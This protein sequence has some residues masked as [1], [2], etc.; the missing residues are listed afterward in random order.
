ML[1]IEKNYKEGSMKLIIQRQESYSR[2][3][4]LLRSFFGV[5]Y[6]VIPHMFLMTFVSIWSG[7]LS[8][9][10]F[11][12]VLFTGKYPKSWFEFQVKMFSWSLRL[13]ASLSN[14]IDGYP[15]NGVNGTSDKVILDVEYPETLSRGELLLRVFFGVIYIVIP[16]MFILSFRMI[17]HQFLSFLSWWAVLFTGKF[18]ESWHAFIVGTFRW[19]TR[20]SLYMNY[21]TD[22][23]PPFSGKE[24]A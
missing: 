6:I 17:A 16:H 12:V 18:P 20:L 3:E 22:T 21:M 9:L 10:A 5:I 7:I 19:T 2:G 14:L 15:A 11:W 1:S 23:Y 24:E 4:L 8:M 13:D